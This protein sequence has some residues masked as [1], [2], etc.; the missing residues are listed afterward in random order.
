MLRRIGREPKI[1]RGQLQR[2]FKN[3]VSP[4]TP[5]EMLKV[6]GR[7]ERVI[8]NYG[9]R[10]RPLRE[11]AAEYGSRPHPD[12]ALSAVL[13][14]QADRGRK[15]YEL[16]SA[17][18]QWF[19][20]TF[21]TLYTIVGPVGAG[22]DVMLDKALPEFPKAI[23]ADFLISREKEPRAVGFAHYDSDRGG[24]Q[25]DDRI[26]GNRDKITE[27]LAYAT[28][29]KSNL[30]V[31]LINDGPGLVLGSMWRD[32]AD[33]EDAGKGRV[34]VATLKMLDDRLTEQWLHV[35]QLSVCL[36]LEA[37]PQEWSARRQS[38]RAM[39]ASFGHKVAHPLAT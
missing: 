7:L 25:E 1:V 33:I 36:D 14:V 2:V 26:G 12:E 31:V 19:E 23:P 29:T 34:L 3:Y 5:V 37:T 38:I 18:F 8:D 13:A 21:G 39:P 17:F 30:K 32:N 10:F 20:A 35:L 24:A 28:R 27:I 15:G 6:V 9:A 4:D 22:P 16:T 11:V